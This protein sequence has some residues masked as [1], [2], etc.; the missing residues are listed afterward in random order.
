[1]PDSGWRN[2]LNWQ[3]AQCPYSC[4]M[5]AVICLILRRIANPMRHSECIFDSGDISQSPISQQEVLGAAMKLSY[6]STGT[7]CSSG[8]GCNRQRSSLSENQFQRAALHD[9]YY[10][11]IK[12]HWS[13]PPHS[14]SSKHHGDI[15]EQQHA[16]RLLSGARMQLEAFRAASWRRWRSTTSL[17][18]GRPPGLCAN[19]DHRHRE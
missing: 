11:A 16:H 13:F 18:L 5:A 3:F 7:T 19:P 14:R 1:M 6:R 15:P 2:S 8:S 10:Y 12:P 17:K 4:A 9:L